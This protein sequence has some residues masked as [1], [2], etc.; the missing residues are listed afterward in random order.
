[1]KLC[2]KISFIRHTIIIILHRIFVFYVV[3]LLLLIIKY[4]YILLIIHNFS[5]LIMI[6]NINKMYFRKLKKKFKIVIL[7]IF[8]F[9]IQCGVSRH[10]YI[11][12]IEVEN[13]QRTLRGKKGAKRRIKYNIYPDPNYELR[14]IK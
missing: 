2:L 1:M 12:C 8:N 10:V 4:I 9:L 7:M 5:I 13:E 3:L 6:K 11:K 14:G